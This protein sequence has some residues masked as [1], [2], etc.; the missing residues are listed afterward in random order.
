M[1]R[2]HVCKFLGEEVVPIGMLKENPWNV[3][4]M[5]SRTFAATREAIRLY[6]FVDPVTVRP[7]QDFYQIIDGEH[8]WRAAMAEGME[9]IGVIKLS[10]PSD[11]VAM[12]LTLILNQ[13]GTPNTVKLA[14]ILAELMEADGDRARL[15]LAFSAKE[16][17]HLVS[18][19]QPTPPY[20]TADPGVVMTFHLAPS[21]GQVVEQA[22]VR[23]MANSGTLQRGEALQ[24]IAAAYLNER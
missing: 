13:H 15:G 23:M 16:M 18:L 14:K 12:K 20:D 22:V 19:S 11:A 5:D 1:S 2:R 17:A 24:R 3:Q 6:G 7:V 21:Q 4:L 9:T 8:R 10:I